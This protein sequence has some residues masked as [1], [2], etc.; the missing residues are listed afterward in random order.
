MNVMKWAARCRRSEPE[1]VE[2]HEAP[3]LLSKSPGFE[4]EGPRYLSFGFDWI[5]DRLAPDSR[6]R[7][8]NGR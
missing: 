3:S 2:L 8:L 6:L 1:A 7:I 4:L 5:A